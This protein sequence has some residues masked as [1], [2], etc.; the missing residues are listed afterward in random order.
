MTRYA[1]PRRCPDC[2]ETLPYGAGQCP[3]CA[4]TLR[5]DDAQALFLTLRRA[6]ELVAVLRSRSGPMGSTGGEPRGSAGQSPRLAAAEPAARRASLSTATVPQ[7]LLALGAGCL[8]V[9]ALVFLAVTWSVLGVGGRT[10]VLVALTALTGTLAGWAARRGLRA[11]TEA[12]GLVALGLLL[13]DVAG[14]WSAGWLGTLGLPGLLVVAG[15]LLAA[16]AASAAVAVRRGTAVRFASGEVVAGLGVGLAALG[17][18]TAHGWPTASL[19]ALAAVLWAVAAAALLDRARLGTAT[20][21]AAAAAALAW[22]DLLAEGLDRAA[23]QPTWSAL[24]AHGGA[25]PLLAAA[26]LA[27]GAAAPPRLPVPVR[28]G[29]AA[30]A[31]AILAGLVLLPTIDRPEVATLVVAVL[32]AAAAAPAWLL[33]RPWGLVSGL[34]L[35]GSVLWTAAVCGTLAI[36]VLL[37]VADT[38]GA[39]VWSSG[40]GARMAVSDVAPD[41]AP[42]LLLVAVP[43]LL[44]GCGTLV[45]LSG[46]E[47]ELIPRSGDPRVAASV[48]AGTV[49]AFCALHPLPVWLVLALL[50]AAAA[51]LAAWW[52]H[53]AATSSL[54]A[55]TGFV[56]AAT[57]LGLAAA[58]LTAA[59]LLGALVL[60]GWVV[61][62]ARAALLAEVAA[63]LAAAVLAGCVWTWSALAGVDA[64]WGALLVLGTLGAVSLLLLVPG[65]PSDRMASGPAIGS[66]AAAVPVMVAGA[67]LA[68]VGTAAAWVAV[69]LTV[70][71]AAVAAHALLGHGSQIQAWAGGALLAAATWVR[72]WDLGIRTPEA[73]TLPSALVLTAAGLW[74][75]HRRPGAATLPAL[76][77]GLVLCLLPSLL[78]VLAEPDGLRPVLLGTACVGLVLAGARLGWAA[79]LMVGAVV[80]ALEVLRLAA[81]FLDASVPRWVLIGAA[82]A[83]LVGAGISWEQRVRDAR[84]LAGYVGRLR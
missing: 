16:A 21:V 84:T 61:L 13:L 18:R 77:P 79:P 19:A 81:P 80:G 15:S 64:A 8:L 20:L 10:G 53:D 45:R 12:L 31:Q 37:T 30:V 7:V 24:W 36:R 42:W 41:L 11:A 47:R 6:D 59:A 68:P 50:L 40:A 22:L 70:T 39:Q 32:T 35:T 55:A 29:G 72:L 5:G 60:A 3:H 23:A 78:R 34:T 73:Y 2:L 25:W 82:G 57:V 62:R 63:A 44:V 52:G 28:V 74:H 56:A 46:P 33:R 65:R 51:G 48:A 54:V 71:G 26:A 69:Y 75:L 58:W 76:T 1:D 17:V 83:L 43:T 4:L 27:A 49:V 38:V 66:A 9:A 14:A 67:A